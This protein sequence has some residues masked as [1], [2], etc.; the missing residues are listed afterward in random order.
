MPAQLP[1]PRPA[2]TRQDL[3]QAARLHAGADR[4]PWRLARALCDWSRSGGSGGNGGGGSS[5][6]GG[7]G[8]AAPPAESPP[9]APAWLHEQ[10]AAGAALLL[11]APPPRPPRPAALAKRLEAL[12]AALDDARYAEMVAD[13]TARE[14]RLAALSCADGA[15]ATTRLQ[16]SFGLHVVVTMG[17][18]FALGFYG[19]RMRTGSDAWAAAGGSLGMAAAL[20]LE[21]ALL[22]VRTNLPEPLERR[23]AHLL[24]PDRRAEWL[25]RDAARLAAA[26]AGGDGGDAAAGLREKKTQ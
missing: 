9:T 2:F 13:V 7:G 1:A 18:F 15:L 10:A 6:S 22:I 14:R 26:A 24:P 19:A 16:L 11:R 25:R 21:T 4:V 12:Q 8:A 5:G 23:Y 20:L 17:A 3:R